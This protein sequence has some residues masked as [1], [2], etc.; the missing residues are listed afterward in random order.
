MS[1]VAGYLPPL[2]WYDVSGVRG[3]LHLRQT[4][5]LRI[6]THF[7]L[8]ACTLIVVHDDVVAPE[9]VAFAVQAWLVAVDKVA[10][11]AV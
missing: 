2:S 7:S 4:K 3:A 6:L 10:P 1:T 5:N 9:P 11:D 8:W